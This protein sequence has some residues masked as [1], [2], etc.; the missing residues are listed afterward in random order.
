MSTNAPLPQPKEYAYLK[1]TP[2]PHKKNNEA[3]SI[4]VPSLCLKFGEIL[5]T[6]PRDSAITSDRLCSDLWDLA[7]RIE[8]YIK[9]YPCTLTNK[10]GDI[11]GIKTTA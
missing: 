4:Q 7:A 11:T 6:F 9:Q 1:A 10:N 3:S 2:A 5:V 8:S